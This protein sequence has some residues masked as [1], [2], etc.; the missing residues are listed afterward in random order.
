[1]PRGN[2]GRN[3]KG[4]GAGE[5]V[6]WQCGPVLRLAQGLNGCDVNVGSE[7]NRKFVGGHGGRKQHLKQNPES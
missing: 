7:G 6:R 5:W 4:T 1:M 3:K 2:A